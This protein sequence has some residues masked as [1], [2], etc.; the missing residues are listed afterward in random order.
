MLKSN[1]Y[2]HGINLVSK[3]L[4]KTQVP[5]ICVDSFPE[6]QIVRDWAKQQVLIL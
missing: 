1:A 3:I 6:Y 2:G 5:Y 4:S